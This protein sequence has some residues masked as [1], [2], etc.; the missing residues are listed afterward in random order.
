M[1]SGVIG[2]GSLENGYNQGFQS[3]M[4]QRLNAF[5]DNA[6]LNMNSSIHNTVRGASSGKVS[7]VSESSNFV[8]AM[9][10]ASSQR[11]H[12]HSLPEFHDTLANGSPYNFTS[13]IS[14]MPSTIGTAVTEAS[15]GRHIQGM[16]STGNLAEFNAG[17]ECNGCLQAKKASCINFLYVQ[18]F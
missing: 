12:P 17:G 8:G 9:K 4:Q 5:T 15:D 14:N 10:F 1:S 16:G 13:T 7:G 11:F 3:A 2:S 6:F 18:Q